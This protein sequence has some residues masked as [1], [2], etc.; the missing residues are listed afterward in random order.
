MVNSANYIKEDKKHED[1][2]K[3]EECSKKEIVGEPEE[4]FFQGN[5][6]VGGRRSRHHGAIRAVKIQ[7]EVCPDVLR[8]LIVSG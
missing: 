2:I 8:F 6:W 1:G 5:G 7:A 3:T 4:Q